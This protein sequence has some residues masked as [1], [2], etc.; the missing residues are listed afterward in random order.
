MIFWK[1][2][3][4]VRSSILPS[5]FGNFFRKSIFCYNHQAFSNKWS[6]QKVTQLIYPLISICSFK[7][8]LSDLSKK[9]VIVCFTWSRS[10][11]KQGKNHFSRSTW[12][13]LID[14]LEKITPHFVSETS[15]KIHL[16][17]EQDRTQWK[18]TVDR[19]VIFWCG[20]NLSLSLQNCNIFKN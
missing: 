1:P 12:T 8:W 3:S 2:L 5:Y 15:C 4:R 17:I 11:P 7:I 18:I 20:R 10:L 14:L 6:V 9:W 19:S 16:M 13:N